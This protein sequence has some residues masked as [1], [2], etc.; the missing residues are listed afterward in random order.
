MFALHRPVPFCSILFALASR[1][2]GRPLAQRQGAVCGGSAFPGGVGAAAIAPDA[3]QVLRPLGAARSGERRRV[4][5]VV[6]VA[7]VFKYVSCEHERW[8]G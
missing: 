8:S 3:G 2:G 6:L 4:F 5:A 1:V 7:V